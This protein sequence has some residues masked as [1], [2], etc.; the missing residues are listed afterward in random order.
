MPSNQWPLNMIAIRMKMSSPANM[1]PNSR[2]DRETGLANRATLSRMKLKAI[3]NGA[4]IRP[5][6]FVFNCIKNDQDED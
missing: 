5:T 3:I 4:A 6:P 2:S 1:L